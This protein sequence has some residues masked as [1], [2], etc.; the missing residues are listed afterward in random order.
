ADEAG[1]EDPEL[2]P[3]DGQ[4]GPVIDLYTIGPGDEWVERWGHSAICVQRARP[5]R[6][7]CYNY[8]TTRFDEPG[9][10][11]WNFLRGRSTFWVST[12]SRPRLVEHYASTD[13]TIWVQ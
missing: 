10:M 4:I 13:R 11:V 2:A 9:T 12:S 7:R 8:G 5:P 1:E 6:G 3:A